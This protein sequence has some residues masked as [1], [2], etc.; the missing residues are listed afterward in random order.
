M[1]WLAESSRLSGASARRLRFAVGRLSA[2]LT[3]S[4]RSGLGGGLARLLGDGRLS[5]GSLPLL[6]M[7]RDVPDGVFRLRG[8]HLD[9]D[10]TI[11]TS[12]GYFAAVRSTMRAVA[13]ALGGRYTDNP[14]W[15]LRRVV[16]VHPLGGAP[17]GRH[18]GEGVCDGHGQVFGHPGLYVLDGSA[19]PGP[20]GPNPAL[21]IAAVV[22]RALDRLL[23]QPAGR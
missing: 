22:D 12:A 16:T 7:G 23:E 21:T 18:R 8:D 15:W 4:P 19:M 10:W 14:A 6:G 17:M 2:R 1:D 20:V 11:R 3:G 5:A 9:V 13:D